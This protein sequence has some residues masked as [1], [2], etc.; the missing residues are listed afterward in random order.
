M[1]DCHREMVAAARQRVVDELAQFRACGSAHRLAALKAAI[2]YWHCKVGAWGKANK[3]EP[4]K[5]NLS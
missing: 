1:T 3:A 2:E 5:Q 4:N